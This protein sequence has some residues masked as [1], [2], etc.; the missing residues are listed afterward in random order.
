MEK[1]I[2]IEEACANNVIGTKEDFERSCN[3]DGTVKKTNQSTTFSIKDTDYSVTISDT[4]LYL[5]GVVVLTL[6]TLLVW[7]LIRQ[8]TKS[9]RA[10]R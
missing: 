9:K 8:K 3:P 7:V 5:G 1:G 4:Y 6:I 2:S 10:K